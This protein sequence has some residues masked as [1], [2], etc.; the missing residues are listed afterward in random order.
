MVD[1]RVFADARDT[2]DLYSENVESMGLT[3]A[4]ISRME[5]K[6]MRRRVTQWHRKRA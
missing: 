4:V 2:K 6:K 5:V 1:G 3:G